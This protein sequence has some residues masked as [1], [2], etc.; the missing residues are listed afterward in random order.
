MSHHVSSR[1]MPFIVLPSA[2]VE[3]LAADVPPP[4]APDR[5]VAGP[6]L[7]TIEEAAARLMLGRS[8]VYALV[9]AGHLESVHIGRCARV[10]VAGLEEF[11]ERI[12]EMQHA[13]AS[14]PPS[15]K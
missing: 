9:A 11:V 1:P 2:P 15:L 13:S 3:P 14:Q 5:A 12:R 8:T 4:P 6:I 7:L 10:P